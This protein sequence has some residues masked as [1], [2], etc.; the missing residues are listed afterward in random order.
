VDAGRLEGCCQRSRTRWLL[1]PVLQGSEGQGSE[2]GEQAE[3]TVRIHAV[4]NGGR[5]AGFTR[6]LHSRP[7][8]GLECAKLLRTTARAQ[9]SQSDERW[10]LIGP[11]AGLGSEVEALPVFSNINV[12][13][14]NVLLCGLLVLGGWWTWFLRDQVVGHEE[15]LQERDAQIVTLTGDLEERARRIEELDDTVAARD[16]EI[17][18]LGIELA[19]REAEIE[20]LELSLW[21]LKVDHRVARITVLDQ[22]E[23]ADGTVHTR[24][25][26]A[27]I[28]PEG[29][30]LGPG[31]EIEV[32]GRTVYVEGLVIK[33]DDAYV[34]MGDNLRGTSVCLLKRLFGESQSPSAGTALDIQTQLPRAYGDEEGNSEQHAELWSRFWDYANDPELA[35]A[36]GVRAI[37][38]EAPYM[39]MRK[40]QSYRLELRASGGMTIVAE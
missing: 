31:R 16:A 15:A 1:T 27:E 40:G 10:A 36:K 35:A 20:D 30:E 17:T 34:E 23:A 3:E 4:R 22:S 39:E 5:C 12:L 37:H 28:N 7:F 8:R 19:A 2:T 32:E 11:A 14:R 33:F 6:N 21:L 29:E 13:L 9:R 38:G 18:N 26:F 24:V 25:R